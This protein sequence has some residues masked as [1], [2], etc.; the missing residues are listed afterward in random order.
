[1]WL[2]TDGCHQESANATR[3]QRV[4]H[5]MR[6]LRRRL[7]VVSVAVVAANVASAVRVWLGVAPEDQQRVLIAWSALI[8]LSS[9]AL[10]IGRQTARR[11]SALSRD[12]RA[13]IAAL[14]SDK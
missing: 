8:L 14:R 1:M 13:L 11:L 5:D 6:H 3:L 9:G 7:I 2:V 4:L 10:V 12:A